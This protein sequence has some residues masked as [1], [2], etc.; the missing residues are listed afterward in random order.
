MHLIAK[1]VSEMAWCYYMSNGTLNQ[2]AVFEIVHAKYGLW[3][4]KM[5]TLERTL[6]PPNFSVSRLN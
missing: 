5:S 2:P 1:I 4:L 3:V 6:V